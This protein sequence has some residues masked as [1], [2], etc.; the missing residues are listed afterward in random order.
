MTSSSYSSNGSPSK[1]DLK[2]QLEDMK[3]KLKSK[4]ELVEKLERKTDDKLLL[5]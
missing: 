4:D 1:E 5:I 3:K 2:Q